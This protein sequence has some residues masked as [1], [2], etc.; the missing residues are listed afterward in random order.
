MRPHDLYDNEAD[1]ALKK[2]V[3]IESVL[4]AARDALLQA[5]RDLLFTPH[6]SSRVMMVKDGV[7]RSHAQ[8]PRVHV[9]SCGPF[10]TARATHLVFPVYFQWSCV[11]QTLLRALLRMTHASPAH[12]VSRVLP[13]S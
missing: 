5:C 2:S 13:C 11:S 8:R 1:A 6:V 10:E 4:P 12:V 7:P 9:I 3:L